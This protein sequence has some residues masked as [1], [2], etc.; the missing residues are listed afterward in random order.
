[1]NK[2]LQKEFSPS[3]SL[4]I[5]KRF[6]FMPLRIQSEI[7]LYGELFQFSTSQSVLTKLFKKSTYLWC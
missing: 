2:H 3:L 7:I 1:M 6:A 5:V 4:S